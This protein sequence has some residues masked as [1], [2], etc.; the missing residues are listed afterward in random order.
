[1]NAEL[2]MIG[3]E[4]LLGQ[5]TDTNSTYLG[6]KLAEIGIDV[7]RKVTVG[8]NQKRIVDALNESLSKSDIVIC[9]GGLGPTVDDM[10][11]ESVSEATNSPLIYHPDLFQTIYDR[12]VK[13]GVKVSENNKK[14]ALLPEG[15][16]PINNP[17][18]TAPGFI[19]EHNSKYI[20]CL[21]GVPFELKPMF[22]ETVIPFLTQK[23]QIKSRIYIKVLKV[24]GL[25]ESR[26]DHILGD[27]LYSSSPTIGLLASP[28][29]VRIRL[30]VKEEEPEKAEGVLTDMETKINHALPGLV[31]PGDD[32]SLEK[33]L[34]A[35]L[36][37]ENSGIVVLDAQTGGMI[38]Y[39]MVQAGM[40]HLLHGE[41][42]P[43]L[44]TE[45]EME[46]LFDRA[47]EYL[48]K[49]IFAYSLIL[50]PDHNK[51]AT[52]LHFISKKY[53]EIIWE[54]PFYGTEERNRVRT[55]VVSLE[56]IRRKLLNIE[57]DKS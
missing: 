30:A 1:M 52:R 42:Y 5:I 36:E 38:I 14:Q 51:R 18:G 33:A 37:K 56:K 49:C 24:Y 16:I 21:P 6:E 54:L 29:C 28:E 25:G 23:F 45:E 15:A 9:S 32:F 3:T 31:L 22:E 7:Y 46:F 47:K 12:F 35:V 57:V 2:L 43:N 48:L 40:K 39:R 20:I 53:G 10:T 34:D 17:I 19:K 8:D 55:A 11:R 13:R 4:L 26:I 50:I 44:K 27:L 41:V